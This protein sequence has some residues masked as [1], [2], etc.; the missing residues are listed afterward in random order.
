M[1]EKYNLR[2]LLLF[3]IYNMNVYS[4]LGIK[5]YLQEIMLFIVTGLAIFSVLSWI[6]T[7]LVKEEK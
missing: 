7:F 3:L 4:P 5:M 6:I 2:L 1:I